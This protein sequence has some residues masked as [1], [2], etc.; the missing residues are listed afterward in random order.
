MGEMIYWDLLGLLIPLVFCPF[1]LCSI[2]ST[3]SEFPT[4]QQGV[5]ARIIFC[6]SFCS[7][8]CASALRRLPQPRFL[9]RLQA[10]QPHLSPSGH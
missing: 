9:G 3:V 4:L 2:L 10:R 8:S 6:L 5:V 1:S 7:F